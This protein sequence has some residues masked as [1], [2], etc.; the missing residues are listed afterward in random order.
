VAVIK[1]P[2]SG[3]G[4]S[5]HNIAGHC[6]RS[7]RVI[8][9]V[10]ARLQA[11]I[12]H[13]NGMSDVILVKASNP[14]VPNVCLIS[15]PARSGPE[16]FKKVF[17]GILAANVVFLLGLLITEYR[18]ELVV[19]AEE[20]PAGTAPPPVAVA[21]ALA[22]SSAP[23]TSEPPVPTVSSIPV[24]AHP[25]TVYSVISNDTLNTIAKRHATTVKA[26]KSANGLS[27]ERL[28]VGQK[29]KIP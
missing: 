18:R 2:A 17:F 27:T 1:C 19:S 29:L 14:F 7:P 25:E 12:L 15:M 8:P 23:S 28:T 6:V 20:L 4:T 11:G 24:A 10:F 22:A 9:P 5:K 21:G 13:A 16:R 3:H 26:I